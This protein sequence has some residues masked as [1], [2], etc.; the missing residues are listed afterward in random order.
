MPHHGEISATKGCS[1]SSTDGMG[2]YGGSIER[3]YNSFLL[4]KCE[5]N[6]SQ[7]FGKGFDWWIQLHFFKW[8]EKNFE[9]GGTT[10]YLEKF[11]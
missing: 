3:A 7:V 6:L 1:I 11:S 4:P 9:K 10:I 8:F 5:G 2:G